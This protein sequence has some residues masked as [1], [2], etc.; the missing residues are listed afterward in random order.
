MLYNFP[1]NFIAKPKLN[2]IGLDLKFFLG[3]M[4]EIPLFQK[5][6]EQLKFMR[7]KLLLVLD[8][9]IFI[10]HSYCSLRDCVMTHLIAAHI[11]NVLVTDAQMTT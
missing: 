1:F 6:H 7:W 11:Y 9:E 4:A 8:I 3:R 5:G 10:H 2:T